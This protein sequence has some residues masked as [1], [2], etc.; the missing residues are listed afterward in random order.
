MSTMWGPGKKLQLFNR[1]PFPN[2][3]WMEFVLL[4]IL[5]CITAVFKK[6]LKQYGILITKKIVLSS[7]AL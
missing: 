5:N 1:T 6:I 7:P 4:A 2:Y 3:D